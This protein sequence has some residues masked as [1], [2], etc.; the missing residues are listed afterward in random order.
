[1]IRMQIVGIGRMET[2]IF[3]FMLYTIL[4]QMVLWN[5]V[6]CI[7]GKGEIFRIIKSIYMK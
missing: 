4:K 6:D 2:I 7:L 5:M 1:M 3:L